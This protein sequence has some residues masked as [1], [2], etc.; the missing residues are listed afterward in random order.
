MRGALL[1]KITMRRV[2]RRWAE[3]SRTH[4]ERQFVGPRSPPGRVRVLEPRRVLNA[5]F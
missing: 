5:V 2:K 3:Q 4:A 1:T